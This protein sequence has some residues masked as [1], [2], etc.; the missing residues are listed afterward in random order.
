[1]GGKAGKVVKEIK[2]IISAQFRLLSVEKEG[3]KSEQGPQV[4][5]TY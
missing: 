2:E 4:Y 1:M 3:E 5:L